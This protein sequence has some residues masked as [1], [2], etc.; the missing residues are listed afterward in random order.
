[1]H[2]EELGFSDVWVSDHLALPRTAPYPPSSYILEPLI[3]LTWA[4]AAT[5]RVGLGT[6]FTLSMRTRWDALRD[7]TDSISRELDQSMAAGIQHIVAEPL[8]RDEDSWLRCSEA[9][10]RIFERV[11]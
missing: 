5:R 3:A 1:M 8:Q 4:A 9:F 6:T 7:G 2:A 10:A 11:R